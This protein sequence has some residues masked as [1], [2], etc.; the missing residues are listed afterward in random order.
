VEL[1]EYLTPRDGRPAPPDARASDLAH[2]QTEMMTGDAEAAA[3]SLFAARVTLVSPGAVGL[4]EGSQ[5]FRRGVLARD[6]DG[7]AVRLL[8]M[9]K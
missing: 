9:R 6:P 1:L 3:R 5:P 7:H 2:W 4:P 8:E